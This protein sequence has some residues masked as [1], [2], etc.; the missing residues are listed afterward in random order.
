M[1]QAGWCPRQHH[2]RCPARLIIHFLRINLTTKLYYSIYS[3]YY[4]RST[5]SHQYSHSSTV[6]HSNGISHFKPLFAHF[7]S[8]QQSYP[9]VC[10]QKLHTDAFGSNTSPPQE[11]EVSRERGSSVLKLPDTELPLY[12]IVDTLSWLPSVSEKR[13]ISPLLWTSFIVWTMDP[14]L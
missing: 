2:Q 10:W 14:I 5:L 8:R 1:N 6:Y 9:S 12:L 11:R 7:N 13:S 3:P 4:R